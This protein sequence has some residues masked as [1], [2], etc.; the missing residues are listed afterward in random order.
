MPTQKHKDFNMTDTQSKPTS[1][2]LK[3][4]HR[5]QR[6]LLQ[7]SEF[8]VPNPEKIFTFHGGYSAG[9]LQGR[10]TEIETT[11]DELYPNWEKL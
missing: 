5:R 3:L 8:N 9:N 7:S 4:V 2:V 1:F 11:L 10:I 6:L